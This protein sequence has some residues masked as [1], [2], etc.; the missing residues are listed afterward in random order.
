LTWWG[1]R[2]RQQLLEDFVLTTNK[3]A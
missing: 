1:K 2:E 3:N